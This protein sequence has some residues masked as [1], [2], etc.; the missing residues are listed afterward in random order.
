MIQS[1]RRI[2][3]AACAVFLAMCAL[4]VAAHADQGTE[5]TGG[6][7]L[8]P[9]ALVERGSAP[10][11]QPYTTQDGSRT[12]TIDQHFEIIGQ[13]GRVEESNHAGE[14]SD[15][16]IANLD[17]M[18]PD[19][20]GNYHLKAVVSLTSTQDIADIS[21]DVIMPWYGGGSPEVPEVQAAGFPT[22]EGVD[23]PA[24]EAATRY[25]PR[26]KAGTYLS[27]HDYEAQGYQVKGMM[28][29]YLHGK[30]SAGQ[31][32]TVTFPLVLTNAQ[33]LDV[34]KVSSA[35]LLSAYPFGLPNSEQRPAALAFARL[36]QNPAPAADVSRVERTQRGQDFYLFAGN[37]QTDAGVPLDFTVINPQLN[38]GLNVGDI[39][40][41][42]VSRGGGGYPS[43]VWTRAADVQ[44][45]FKYP[46]FYRIQLDKVKAAYRTRGWN[47]NPQYGMSGGYYTYS[48]PS[49]IDLR[50][51]TANSDDYVLS[52]DRANYY[53]ELWRY[54]SAKDDVCVPVG[55]SA[56]QAVKAGLNWVHPYPSGGVDAGNLADPLS[57]SRVVVDRGALDTAV[58]GD[59]PVTYTYW[60]RAADQAAGRVENSASV[61]TMVHVR[62]TTGCVSGVTYLD[63]DANGTRGG[64]ESPLGGV[65]VEVRDSSG[66]LVSS[67]VTGDDGR[68]VLG[69]L[70]PGRSYTVRFIDPSGY[71]SST[72]ELGDEVTVA[73]TQGALE[74][75]LTAQ[76]IAPVVLSVG[77]VPSATPTPQ[78][79][80]AT[81]AS[82]DEATFRPSAPARKSVLARTGVSTWGWVCAGILLAAGGTVALR[83]RAR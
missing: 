16:T 82:T 14:G 80:E 52:A 61:T 30:L 24:V 5:E 50:I 71:V 76:E 59:Y 53:V 77:Y 15:Y 26:A 78:V 33:I 44:S 67:Q 45:S 39:E 31:K 9:A 12:L 29:A 57:G 28:Y 20:E 21:Y 34:S 38:T 62:Q 47:V 51:K 55:S 23:A 49:S 6:L 32:L 27:A 83:R 69:N 60:Q 36:S 10:N 70:I 8:N 72:M 37:N 25:S 11:L 13:D 35:A 43:P 68:F 22:F 19:A 73:R 7:S 3:G 18:T 17:Q 65:T 4:P 2:V 46:W 1:T 40:I 66:A 56:D 42:T 64:S 54:L 48:G 63:R 74:A 75:S 58:E 81:P 41:A 79:S